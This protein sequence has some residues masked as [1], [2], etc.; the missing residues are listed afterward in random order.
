MD[1][2][3]QELNRREEV[4]KALNSVG[5]GFCLA[6][7]NQV[8]IHLGSGLTHSCHHPAPHKVSESEVRINPSALHNTRQKKR[9]R[10]CM[11][12]GGRPAEC[13]YCWRVEDSSDQ[14]SDRIFKSCEPW[15][16][17]TLEEIKE[18]D[19][20][21]DWFPRYVEI[22]FSNKCNQRCLYCGPS[23]SSAWQ[24]E[25]KK[26]GSFKLP[27]MDYNGPLS[28]NDEKV[29]ENEDNEYRKAFWKWWPDMFKHLHTFRITGG[30]PILDQNTIRVLK[31]IQEHWEENPN[32]GLAINSNLN[33]SEEKLE[34]VLEI[35]SDL[36]NNNKV[37]E[38]IFY[39]SIE[40]VG[41]QAE[42]IRRGMHS[43]RFW[44]N[45]ERV[46]Q[47]L[48][49]TT[50]TI[51]ATYNILSIYSYD[52]LI[53]KVYFLKKKYH[54]INRIYS[55][56]VMLDTSYLR[57]P[58]FLSVKLCSEEQKEL[59]RKTAEKVES[60]RVRM[61]P[62]ALPPRYCNFTPGFCDLEIEKIKRIYD[63]VCGEEPFDRD[64]NLERFQEFIKQVD[65]REGT[66]F[67]ETF[68]EI[69]KNE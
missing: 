62:E 27:Q 37:R 64:L 15:A 61:L 45:V 32:I 52:D 1:T 31:Y 59:I 58:T 38:L 41:S 8:T 63:Y 35:L 19:W 44:K 43:D 24:Q 36:S 18:S 47:A 46:L 9:A 40:A 60:L 17:P 69:G 56:A 22:S 26:H 66:K 57:W 12:E 16:W 42:Y 30:E 39:T 3:T 48:P 4:K 53:D 25:A 34:E 50:L 2:L 68:K 33:V 23:F 20:Q 6:K 7:W 5:P 29:Q 10:R 65:E 21:D 54:H 49:K 11:L 28:E 51:M 13:D 67:V 55:T 14:Y